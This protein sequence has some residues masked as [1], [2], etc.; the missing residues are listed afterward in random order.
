MHSRRVWIATTVL[1]I[2]HLAVLLAGFLSPYDP[3][4]QD[5]MRAYAPPTRLHF[6]DSSGFH[7]RPFV[8]PVRFVTFGEYAEDASANSPVHFFCDGSSYSVLGLFHSTH[9][10][11]CADQDTHLA[12]LGTDAFGRDVFSRLLYGA[13]ISLG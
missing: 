10:L 11:F 5:R 7:L 3:G 2:L 13:Q 6:R 4:A 1:V 9:H 12:L 8:H